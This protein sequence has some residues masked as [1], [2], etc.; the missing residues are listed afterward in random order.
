MDHLVTE[1][2]NLAVDKPFGRGFSK[3]PPA[4]EALPFCFLRY[5]AN[6]RDHN[7]P[8]DYPSTHL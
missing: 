1:Q 6:A 3:E 7:K 2:E 8:I 4:T 5:H